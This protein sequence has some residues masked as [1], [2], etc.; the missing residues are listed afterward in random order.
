MERGGEAAPLLE[1]FLPLPRFG[2]GP[3]GCFARGEGVREGLQYRGVVGRRGL[4]KQAAGN[5]F[6]EQTEDGA[7]VAFARQAQ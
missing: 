4:A 3:T 2:G 1:S 5:P 6:A 7:G